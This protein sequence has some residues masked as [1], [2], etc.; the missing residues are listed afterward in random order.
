MAEF[1]NRHFEPEAP[2]PAV[3]HL[4]LNALRV[5]NSAP[6]IHSS[7]RGAPGVTPSLQI[8]NPKSKIQN[9]E[10][11]AFSYLFKVIGR[12]GFAPQL[13]HCLSCRRKK[14]AAFSPRLGGLL[15]SKCAGKDPNSIVVT[16]PIL[17]SL[18][19]LYYGTFEQN[20]HAPVSSSRERHSFPPAFD[21]VLQYLR[22]HLD[23]FD[24][25]SLR[26]LSREA[27]SQD[28]AE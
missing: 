2:S 3:F 24:L 21:L 4:L 19:R 7:S 26:S 1:T 27:R 8:P 15:C 6:T 12:L 25:K 20:L 13:E 5:L 22:F 9:E 17:Q 10:A 14:A 11:V 18:H 28:E 16:A 23:R